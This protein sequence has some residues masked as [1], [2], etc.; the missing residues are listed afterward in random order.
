MDGRNCRTPM[1][2][3]MNSEG[4]FFQTWESNRSVRMENVGESDVVNPWLSNGRNTFRNVAEIVQSA[5]TP[6][7]TD[8]ERARPSGSRK[9]N[10]ATTRRGDNNELGDPVKVF[11]VYG[12]NTCGN[13]SI[14]LGTLWKQPASARPRPG[15]SDIA[16]RR[17]STT[18]HGISWT[19]TA[20]DLSAPRQRDR[21]QRHAVAR[22]HDLVKRPHSNGILLVDTQ[23]DGQGTSALYF[24]E[25][26]D[27]GRTFGRRR[28]RR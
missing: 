23:W 4:A 5:I 2:V 21:G 15:R 9:F 13:D 11:N 25:M 12:F 3:G 8:A 22:D 7:M 6:D 26:R 17:S 28:T 18:A 14:C 10:I 27:R 1:G 19:A 24:T 16:S 20:L